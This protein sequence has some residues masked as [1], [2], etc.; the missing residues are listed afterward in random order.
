M[1]RSRTRSCVPFRPPSVRASPGATRALGCVQC[2]AASSGARHHHRDRDRVV[3][4]NS[5]ASWAMASAAST[6]LRARRLALPPAAV[7]LLV[8]LA[9]CAFAYLCAA[10]LCRSQRVGTNQNTFARASVRAGSR[11]ASWCGGVARGRRRS[12]QAPVAAA[13]NFVGRQPTPDTPEEATASPLHQARPLRRCPLLGDTAPDLVGGFARCGGR[14]DGRA[15]G[16]PGPGS[17]PNIRVGGVRR[18]DNPIPPPPGHLPPRPEHLRKLNH[19][20]PESAFCSKHKL[21]Q[22]EIWPTPTKRRNRPR[23]DQGRTTFANTAHCCP[24]SPAIG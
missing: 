2:P 6:G 21:T 23:S 18:R 22:P 15:P 16:A 19:H 9:R 11:A 3:R 24:V 12:A 17:T 4:R 8:Q 10:P 13:L 1:E 7:N 14:S 5:T 20:L